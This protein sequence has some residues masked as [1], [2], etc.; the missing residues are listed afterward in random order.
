MEV[1]IK[2]PIT[3][4]VKVEGPKGRREI[5][6]VLD[7]GAGCTCI[8]W[9]IAKDIGYDPAISERRVEIITANGVTEVPLIKV[10]SISIGEL[11]ARN[12]DTICHNIP[13]ISTVDGLIGLSF[14]KHF[15]LHM[16]FKEGKMRIE[17][18]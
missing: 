7:T 5:D 1:E 12:V 13:E 15:D 8:S 18:P 4:R 6:A 2:L 14:L 11:E 9:D 10:D 3:L 16:N 17:D